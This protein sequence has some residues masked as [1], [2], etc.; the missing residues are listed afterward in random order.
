MKVLS[1]AQAPCMAVRRILAMWVKQCIRKDVFLDFMIFV[2]FTRFFFNLGFVVSFLT[3]NINSL[4][5]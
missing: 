1:L 5:T 2:I 4:V 3:L